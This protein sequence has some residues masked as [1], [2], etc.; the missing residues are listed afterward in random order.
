[1]CRRTCALFAKR[2]IELHEEGDLDLVLLAVSF[3]SASRIGQRGRKGSL[4][5]TAQA[6][7]RDTARTHVTESAI[8]VHGGQNGAFD[9]IDTGLVH[10]ARGRR[11]GTTGLWQ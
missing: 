5:C 4:H 2:S 8:G 6:A 9:A 11:V 7:R 3:G 1:M 10:L